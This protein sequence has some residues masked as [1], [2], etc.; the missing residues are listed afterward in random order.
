M[1][2]LISDKEVADVLQEHI[3]ISKASAQDWLMDALSIAPALLGIP[4]V[5]MMPM[6]RYRGAKKTVAAKLAKSMPMVKGTYHEPFVGSG[7]SL[8]RVGK[9][10][11]FKEAIVADLNPQVT[12]Y[13]SAIKK[14]PEGVR[15]S[16]LHFTSGL[17]RGEQ[18]KVLKEDIPFIKEVWNQL[19]KGTYKEA[20][21]AGAHL[22]LG[23]YNRVYMPGEIPRVSPG[24]YTLPG[25]TAEK[26]MNL[27]EIMQKRNVKI[28]T[29]SWEKSL[30][31]VKPGDYVN[32]DTPYLK[33]LG[34]PGIKNTAVADHAKMSQLLEELSSKTSGVVYN[35]PLGAKEFPWLTFKPTGLLRGQEVVGEW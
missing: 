8:L 20:D 15:K 6:M 27:G 24:N 33:T 19:Q 2:Q 34:Y 32:L 17:I 28:K 18:G 31:D 26:I 22:F 10:G 16:F 7:S 29:Q 1:E 13:L 5:P 9:A 23:N 3:G 30:A 12:E 4:T 14:D 21:K 35:S 25:S 11:K